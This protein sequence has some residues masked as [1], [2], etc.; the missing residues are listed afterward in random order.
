M[1]LSAT[2]TTS[3]GRWITRRAKASGST[4]KSLRLA[5]LTP[6][7]RGPTASA[8]DLGLVVDLDQCGHPEF[9]RG[10]AM[11]PGE[12]AVGE[13]GHDERT[14][15]GAGAASWNWYSSTMKSLRR[16]GMSTAA[17]R[18]EVR[19]TPAEASAR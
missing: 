9:L 7:R 19:E 5:A 1:P 10:E 16:T 8:L 3:A 13:R 4:A 14:R 18:V 17:H 12:F 15:S 6:S 11:E 2:A